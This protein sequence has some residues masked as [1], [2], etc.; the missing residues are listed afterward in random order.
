MA[1][2]MRDNKERNRCLDLMRDVCTALPM[3]VNRQGKILDETRDQQAIDRPPFF[4]AGVKLVGI[5]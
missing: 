4:K 5:G 2:L 1:L 3:I